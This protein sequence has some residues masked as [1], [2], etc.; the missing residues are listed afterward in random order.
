MKNGIITLYILIG[1]CC[2]SNSN[3]DKT[4]HSSPRAKISQ[5]SRSP[6]PE[7]P[8]TQPSFHGLRISIKDLKR[9]LWTYH[10]FADFPK[11]VDTLH[12]LTDSTGY[13]Y[14]CEFEVKNKISY[15]YHQDTLEIYEYGYV[16][17]VYD[18]GLEVK[19]KW[20]YVMNNNQLSLTGYGEGR[21]GPI[22]PTNN[23][24]IYQLLKTD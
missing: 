14:R 9:T 15:S 4:A 19:Y 24:V 20:Q 7:G 12:F 13:E 8:D 1:F 23:K 2:S 6:V 11:C 3:N 17:E 18:K 21:E 5:P 10:P 16:S 22:T